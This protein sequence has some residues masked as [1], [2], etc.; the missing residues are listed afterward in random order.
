MEGV[1][2]CSQ[3][4]VVSAKQKC[5]TERQPVNQQQCH[6][7]PRLNGHDVDV[8]LLMLCLPGEDMATGCSIGR[9]QAS[10]TFDFDIHVDNTHTVGRT[11][12]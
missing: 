11:S 2:G 3:N 5:S 7:C 12:I 4:V 8:L 6:G 1:V 9:R 10:A